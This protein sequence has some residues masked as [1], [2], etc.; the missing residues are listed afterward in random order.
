MGDSV[1][2]VGAGLSGSL[3]AI[4][5]ARRGHRVEVFER[6]G[7]PRVGA[8]DA[9]RSINLGLSARGIMALRR[10][11]LWEEVR[12]LTVPMRGRLVH[13]RGRPP[14][15][16]P[17]GRDPAQILYSIRR[18]A[19]A[20]L[21]VS[22]AEKEQDVRFFFDTR[23]VAVDRERAAVTVEGQAGP[24]EVRAD[25]VVGADGAF[26]VV[27]AETHRGLPADFR[28]EFLDWG[29]KELTIPPAP[30][31]G[32]RVPIEALHVWPGSEGLVVGHPNLDDSLTCTLFMAHDRLTALT[33]ED[34]AEALFLEHFPGLLD[35][36]PDLAGQVTAGPV[37]HLVTVRTSP[38]RHRDRV[39]LVGDACHAVYPFYGQGMNSSFEDCVVLDERMAAHPGD[40]AAAFAAYQELRRPHTDVLAE[41]SAQ[42]FLELRDGLRSPLHLARKK[43]DRA[44]HR[45]FPRAW[46]PL[47]TLVSHTTTPY[48]DALRRAR[49]QDRVA[50]AAVL[51]GAA[52][53]AAAALRGVRRARGDRRGPS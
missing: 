38:W 52:L 10:A 6:R 53:L 25:F 49:V 20:T 45:L 8:H 11:E 33:G 9:G 24:R 48:G 3:L 44:L 32:P 29:Y 17:Y 23:C 34:E 22:R 50:G 7:D 31:G 26:S 41:L 35:L 18:D 46:V 19:L 47:Y 42:N 30:G 21:L 27:R 43:T 13:R 28:Q 51:A 5:L 15:F 40:R 14:T 36:V 39:V 4:L 1:T 2:I 16:H 12:P 37:G